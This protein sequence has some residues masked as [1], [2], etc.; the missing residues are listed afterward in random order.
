MCDIRKMMVLT[1]SFKCCCYFEIY[2]LVSTK[3]WL[4][5]DC[6]GYYYEGCSDILLNLLIL[7]ANTRCVDEK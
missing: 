4:R 6:A 7:V 3:T 5:A 2:K 1:I